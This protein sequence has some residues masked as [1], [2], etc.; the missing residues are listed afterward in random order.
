M[1]KGEAFDKIEFTKLTTFFIRFYYDATSFQYSKC[2]ESHE[3]CLDQIFDKEKEILL[4][5]RR[6]SVSTVGRDYK[7]N[8]IYQTPLLI[9]AD[10]GVGFIDS[11]GT[12]FRRSLIFL[13]IASS[14]F[15]SVGS[16][17]LTRSDH[18]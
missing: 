13:P 9:L 4:F 5:D 11:V 14:I 8:T 17:D 10:T 16:K 18:S 15:F 2:V 1:H 6:I 12:T 7:L 3:E